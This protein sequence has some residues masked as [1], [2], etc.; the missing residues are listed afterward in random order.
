MRL[1]PRAGLERGRCAQPSQVWHI[2]PDID[3]IFDIEEK[4]SIYLYPDMIS[5][6]VISCTTSK[7]LPLISSAYISILQY[8]I[9]PGSLSAAAPQRSPPGG[10]HQLPLPPAPRRPEPGPGAPL[11]RAL[12]VRPPP[13]YWRHCGTQAAPAA[14]VCGRAARGEGVYR[15]VGALHAQALSLHRWPGPLEAAA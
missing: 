5:C 3:K 8:Q 9:V 11:G 7:I 15:T 2:V 4:T 14:G 1:D 10:H 13:C 6:T 12:P